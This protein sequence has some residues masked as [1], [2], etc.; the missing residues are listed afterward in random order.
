MSGA[1]DASQSG[2]S[3]LGRWLAI[4]SELPC[5]EIAFLFAGQVVG[6]SIS[7]VQG[8][9]TGGLIGALLGFLIGA[10]SVYL[11]VRSYER[12]SQSPPV[13]KP[14]MPS[15]E[16]ILREPDFLKSKEQEREPRE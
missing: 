3:E 15:M 10:Y 4:A 9:V 16:E 1:N 6:Q 13:R 5:A 2:N 11:S 12:S 7:G 8:S 14:Y